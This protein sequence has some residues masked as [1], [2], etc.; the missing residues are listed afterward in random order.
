MA[1][2]ISGATGFIGTSVARMLVAQGET[3]HALCRSTAD[4]SALQH[5][6]IVICRG[7]VSDA[8]SV[9]AAMKGCDRVFHLAAY[10]RN[11]AK[12]P[13]TFT[14]INLGGLTNM[15]NAASDL[16]V[17]RVV[18]TSTNL[19]LSP[20]RGSLVNEETPREKELFTPYEHSKTLAEARA[21]EFAAKG[22]E[23]VIVNPS[24]VFGPGLLS[25]G[26]STTIM[27]QMYMQGKFRTILGNGHAQGNWAFVEDV[28]RG[29]LLAMEKGRPGERYL[30]GGENAS[31]NQFFQALREVSGVNKMLFNVPAGLAF[32]LAEIETFRGRHTKHHPLISP[33]WVKIFLND[34]EHSTEKSERELGYTVTPLREALDRTVRWIREQQ[35]KA[36]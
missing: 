30:L 5:P 3:V 13:E 2:L 14:R 20:S 31:F 10:A 4:V 12:D 28:A 34:W 16:G 17:R 1:V 18:F 23:V 7:D 8:A 19:T 35:L 15:L 25:E 27:I 24:R 22:Q 29:H 11:W 36:A 33:G 32:A 9:K 6:Q 21:R 26:N